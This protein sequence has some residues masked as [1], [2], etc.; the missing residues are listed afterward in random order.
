MANFLFRN[1]LFVLFI[2]SLTSVSYAQSD[3]DP[4]AVPYSEDFSSLSDGDLPQ[5]WSAAQ[6][7][8]GFPGAYEYSGPMYL[9]FKGSNCVALPQMQLPINQLRVTF[10][11]MCLQA[12]N[13][14]Q[15]GVLSDP[16][17]ASSFTVVET[18]TPSSAATFESAEVHFD[19]YTGSGQYIAF[20]TTMGANSYAL[21][22]NVVVSEMPSCLNPTH[23]A[24]SD[25]TSST[26]TLSWTEEGTAQQWRGIL[27]TTP[28]PNYSSAPFEINAM[29]YNAQSLSAQTTYYFYVQ[30]VCSSTEASSF[31]ET[32][33]TT[34]C[35]SQ[36]LPVTEGFNMPSQLPGCWAA[37]AIVG[38]VVPSVV[39]SGVAPSTMPAGGGSMVCWPSATQ[40][41]GHQARLVSSPVNTMGAEALNVHFQWNHSINTEDVFNEG[42]MVQYS[43]NGLEWFDS[44][45]GFIHQGDPALEG[46]TPYDVE[47]PA[48]GNHP[49]IYVGFLFLSD[50]H[51][52]C[53]LDELTL[54]AAN[55]CLTP[56]HVVVENVGGNSAVVSWT[57]LGNSQQW[58]V[59]VSELPNPAAV[60]DWFVVNEIPYTIQ[61]LNPT[62]VYYVYV[63]SVCANSS[64]SEWSM[65]T[66]FMTGCGDILY[67]PYEEGFDDYGT[68][69]DAFPSCWRR[70]RNST[71]YYFNMQTMDNCMT[72]SAT[73]LS[74]VDGG[75]SLM[76]CTT[77]GRQS[78]VVSP[79]IMEEIHNVAV[80][81]FLY[82]EDSQY[83]GII[84]VG[85]M[86]NCEDMATF[87]SIATINPEEVGEWNFYKIPFNT[88][89]TS[90]TEKYIAFRHNS[91][92]DMNY[93][94]LDN[95][96]I[97]ENT[98]CWHAFSLEVSNIT[99]NSAEF[100]WMDVNEGGA[101]WRMEISEELLPN[102]NAPAEVADVTFQGNSFSIDYL[103]GGRTYYYSLS[104]VC[105][106]VAGEAVTGQFTTLP[107]NCYVDL[108]LFD[109]YNN[110]WEGASLRFLRGGSLFAQVTL[111]DGS[112]DTVRL[113]T[114]ESG[115]IACEF[116]GGGYDGDI[117]FRIDDVDGNSLYLQD[118]LPVP[119]VFFSF[120]P[121][122]GVAC[123]QTPTNVQASLTASGASVSWE[124]APEAL[125]YN[126]YRNNILLASYV[127]G[128]TY[129]D[130]AIV[131]GQNCYTVSSSCIVGE[132]SPSVSSC[133]V[134]VEEYAAADPFALY[135]N[136]ARERLFVEAQETISQIQ[137]CNVLG[138]VLLS[139]EVNA[140]RAEI[141]LPF[142]SGVY[143]LRAWIGGRA[144]V[145]RFVIH[146]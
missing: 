30:S 4:F 119:G 45:Q 130:N 51:N 49:T 33:F 136:P 141:D 23:V 138:E 84:E 13:A 98:D 25:V 110:G 14:I 74:S 127:T 10:D 65:P 32:V 112:A 77:S 24:A 114:C 59:A 46:W 55:G 21:L 81:F 6:F 53:Y 60:N 145:S 22:D 19:T 115:P 124:A 41:S 105:D 121:S 9:W 78:Y 26:A 29:P 143:F 134:G 109:S 116:V 140:D 16:T 111:E 39:T 31:S 37:E 131:N 64:F 1:I 43:F 133:V 86:S 113:Y 83:S 129:Q 101:S 44:P 48:A 34:S 73:D 97:E 88:A 67:L 125:S 61:N 28:A 75:H 7:T 126:V 27:S 54:S 135:P 66:S 106:G 57:E 50:H 15:V 47:I 89:Q 104:P 120:S 146:K 20:R 132:S 142:A 58:E 107:C 123:D 12:G 108:Y 63:R 92:S 99:G 117:T 96:T 68:C 52:N 5:C 72:P 144:S 38:N 80:T 87:E 100:N 118:T 70:H 18:I 2:L 3:C 103:R 85:V 102:P 93:Y 82:K 137:V 62:T 91:V 8:S 40:S 56:A 139:Q 35:A 79:P 122:C 17:S 69:S 71:D 11:V 76:F 42:V 94:L 128:N 95:L 90:G 36:D